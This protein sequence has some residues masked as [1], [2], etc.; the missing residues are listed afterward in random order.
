MNILSV[1]GISDD[2]KI[3]VLLNEGV[4][5]HLQPSFTGVNTITQLLNK[6]QFHLSEIILGGYKENLNIPLPKIDVIY[7]SICNYDNQKKSISSFEQKFSN[8]EIPI[9]NHP[10]GIKKSTRDA[11]YEAFKNNN[12]F[13]VPKTVRVIPKSVKDVFAIAEK[14][15]FRFPFIFRSIGENN[16]KNMERIDSLADSDK[17]EQFAFDGR[18]FYMIQYH[19]YVSND[20]LYRKYRALMIDGELV[21]RHLLFS[22]EWKNANF[23]GHEKVVGRMSQMVAKEEES[24][25]RTAPEAKLIEM[26]KA[27]YEFLGLDFFGFDFAFDKEGNII[28]FEANSCMMAYYSL[29]YGP[30]YLQEDALKIKKKLE[31][32][33]INKIK[34]EK[35]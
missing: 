15:E 22:D 10:S 19:E 14:F 13:I 8:S 29:D 17:L 5:G 31:T 7:L 26:S 11:I 23:D 33:F 25:L 9:L 28:L 34:K 12:Q 2:N 32:M 20:G 1:Y 18:E 27:L 3:T 21:L 4:A 24:F 30:K 35:K 6:E 16:A